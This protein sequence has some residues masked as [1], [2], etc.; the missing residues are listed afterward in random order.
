MNF[1]HRSGGYYGLPAQVLLSA[2]GCGAAGE[3]GRRWMRYAHTVIG[4]ASVAGY[5]ENGA[6]PE[7]VRWPPLEDNKNS[8][9]VL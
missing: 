4:A 1:S 3:E 6:A 5:R 8:W 9:W 7:G 2:E